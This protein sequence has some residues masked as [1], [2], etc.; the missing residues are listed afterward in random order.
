MGNA[1]G[2]FIGLT[3]SALDTFP[4]IVEDAPA[5]AEVAD[6]PTP[7]PTLPAFRVLTATEKQLLEGHGYYGL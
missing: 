3:R 2:C 1:G 4:A 7:A 5:E 6:I